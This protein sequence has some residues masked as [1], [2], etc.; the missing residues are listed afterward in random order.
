MHPRP[1]KVLVAC[2]LLL[3]LLL[4]PAP[5]PLAPPSPRPV[6]LSVDLLRVNVEWVLWQEQRDLWNATVW[7]NAAKKTQRREG[8]ASSSI[9][10]AATYAPGSVESIVCS[11]FGDTCPR[12]LRIATC[13]SDLDPSAYN[14]SG[15]SG[16]FE[17]MLP[18]HADVFD[19]HGWSASDWA[20]PFKNATVAYDLSSG[21]ANW[22]AWVCQ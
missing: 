12:A 10:D 14:R 9:V 19:A 17:I 7:E 16:L 20:D 15:A 18:L 2:C 11:V 21:G 8:T 1:L 5:R 13:E 4:P 22:S 6:P 3:L